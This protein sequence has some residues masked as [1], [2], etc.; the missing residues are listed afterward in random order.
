MFVADISH[1][2]ADAALLRV[3]NNHVDVLRTD[4]VFMRLR[5]DH[6]STHLAVDRQRTVEQLFV[7]PLD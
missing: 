7:E 3:T 4:G 6:T 2:N 5:V 1:A